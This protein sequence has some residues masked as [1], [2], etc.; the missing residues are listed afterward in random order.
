VF[1]SG[2][3]PQCTCVQDSCPLLV[4]VYLVLCGGPWS[5]WTWALYREIRMDQFEFF[6]MLTYSWTS[7]I[8]WKC[9]LF[10]HRMVLVFVKDQMTIGVWVHFWVSILFHLSTCLSLYQY[11][12][13][14][15]TIV[16]QYSLRL[17]MVILPEVLLAENS[18]CYCGFFV[19]TNEF[20][21]LSF[22]L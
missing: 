2:N 19:I 17:E 8:C 20:A 13:A 3:F 16:L 7:K 4:W 5:S 18:F 10:F 12:T 11:H 14:F 22:E 9:N 21:N 6:Y 15:I 1:C